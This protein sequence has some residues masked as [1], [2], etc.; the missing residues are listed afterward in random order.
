[1]KFPFLLGGV[2]MDATSVRLRHHRAILAAFVALVSLTMVTAPAVAENTTSDSE[3]PAPELRKERVYFHCADDTMQYQNVAKRRGNM[4]SWDTAPPVGTTEEGAGCRYLE[5]N[6]ATREAEWTGTFT[7]NLR[8]MTIITHRIPGAFEQFY[9][10]GRP[11]GTWYEVT[12]DGY[13]CSFGVPRFDQELE[14]P[15]MDRIELTLAGFPYV[16]Y[17]SEPGEGETVRNIRVRMFNYPHPLIGVGSEW[18][19][20]AADV[21]S[22]IL[23]N[24]DDDAAI[25]SGFPIA[26]FNCFG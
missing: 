8:H 26:R 7:G 4:P 25:R 3:Q 5:V 13:T 23:F 22:G 9:M 14:D 10:N 12:V 16:K 15:E 6:S 20:D 24:T 11:N 21:D 19:F 1:M 17:Q 18:L 2:P